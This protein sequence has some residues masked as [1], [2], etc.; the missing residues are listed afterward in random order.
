[1]KAA[2]FAVCRPARRA[3]SATSR[4]SAAS[5]NP[6]QRSPTAMYAATMRG[7]V[8]GSRRHHREVISRR[9]FLSTALT[10]ATDGVGPG[11]ST[12]PV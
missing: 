5:E 4:S 11:E 10:G 1:M 8:Q 12:G 3:G 9:L 6:I 7:G 2:P